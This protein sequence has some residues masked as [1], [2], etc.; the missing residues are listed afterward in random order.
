MDAYRAVI[1]L[2]IVLAIVIVGL[3]LFWAIML[4]ALRQ[5]FDA[6]QTAHHL[7]QANAA[8]WPH[9][10][11]PYALRL[12]LPYVMWGLLVLVSVTGYWLLQVQPRGGSPWLT[13]KLGLLAALVLLQIFVTR[14]PA[15]MPIRIILALAVLIVVVSALMVRS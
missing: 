5:K 14:R 7:A 2:H 15:P 4:L 13:I 12:P 1:G 8:R 9:V 10:V 11:V 6:T 3:A